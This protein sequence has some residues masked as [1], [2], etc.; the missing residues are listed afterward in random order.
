MRN[1]TIIVLSLF[2][3]SNLSCGT[4]YL[5]SKFFEKNS[6]PIYSLPTQTR[7]Q[8]V[9]SSNYFKKQITPITIATTSLS[10][11]QTLQKADEKITESEKEETEEDEP[12]KVLSENIFDVPFFSQFKDITTEKWKKVGCGIASMAMIIDYYKP[13]EVSANSLLNEGIRAGAYIED[14]GWSHKGL[15][16]LADDHGLVGT[17]HDLSSSNMD[18]AFDQFEKT[19]EKGPVIASVHYTFEPTNPIPHLA[20][21]NGIK[22]DTLYYS[23]PAEGQGTISVEKFK[24]A[25]KKRYIEVR[26]SV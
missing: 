4:F 25:W 13:A 18:A 21:I 14:A 8:L 7:Q 17:T 12:K 3:I 22:G 19:L 15:A 10:E 23:D 16:L 24:R 20:V 26:P 5:A 11:K 2:I 9:E 1:K 6:A